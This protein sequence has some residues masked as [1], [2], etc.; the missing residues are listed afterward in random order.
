MY[1][2]TVNASSHSLPLPLIC[3]ISLS[4]DFH[5]LKWCNSTTHTFSCKQKLT[6]FELISAVC[7]VSH[8]HSHITNPRLSM[9]NMEYHSAFSSFIDSINVAIST[10]C[11]T[12]TNLISLFLNL[13]TASLNNC[14][15]QSHRLH[16]F[17]SSFVIPA[18]LSAYLLAM[19]STLSSST[20]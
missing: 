8:A 10:L 7:S 20:K 6:S 3:E 5:F 16:L 12:S 2:T 1:F 18:R 14:C 11:Q 4:L 19:L 13:S 17:N 15:L 9:K